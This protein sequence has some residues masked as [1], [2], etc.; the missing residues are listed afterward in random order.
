VEEAHIVFDGER[1][2]E[3]DKLTKLKDVDEVY[4]DTLFP[5]IYEEVLEL[6]KKGVKVCLLRDASILKKLRIENNG[7]KAMRMTQ[8]CFQKP[9][10][11]SSEF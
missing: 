1:I 11:M 10:E 6:L 5:E 2:F 8:Y 3:V 4:I 7:G 9:Q